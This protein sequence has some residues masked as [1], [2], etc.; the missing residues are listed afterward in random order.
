MSKPREQESIGRVF[1]SSPLAV[2]LAVAI[3]VVF[4]ALMVM[5]VLAILRDR[6]RKRSGEV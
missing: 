2:V 5:I 3:I 1:V 4:V 6:A